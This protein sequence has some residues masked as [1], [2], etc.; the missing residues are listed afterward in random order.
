[1]EINKKKTNDFNDMYIEC[2]N[3]TIAK[4]Y[5]N[6]GCSYIQIS[7]YGLY[8][9][10]KDI[11]KFNVPYFKYRQILRIRTKIH[12]KCDKNG[13]IR[14]SVIVSPKPFIITKSKYSLDNINNLPEIFLK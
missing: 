2:P 6:K 9:L 1:M 3:T 13:F 7:K 4:L 14:A 10:G 12:N 11:C 5:A 8:H